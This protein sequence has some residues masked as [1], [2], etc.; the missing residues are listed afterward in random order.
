MFAT[1]FSQRCCWVCQP[2]HRL[3][4]AFAAL[5]ALVVMSPA[6]LAQTVGACCRNSTTFGC[7]IVTPQQCQAQ[8]GL[9]LGGTNCGVCDQPG[10]CCVNGNC[11][12][13]P[14]P[15][16]CLSQNGTYFPQGVACQ[17]NCGT[18]V[19]GACCNPATGQC[20]LLLAVDCRPPLLFYAGV[21]CQPSPCD[22]SGACCYVPA[23]AVNPICVQNSQS[24]CAQ[25]NGQWFGNTSCTAVNCQNV[26]ACCNQTSGTCVYTT[27]NQ[28]PTAG[29][30]FYP[31]LPCAAVTDCRPNVVCCLP[32]GACAVTTAQECDAVA[33]QIQPT[34]TSCLPNPCN[35][36]GACCRNGVCVV[37]PVGQCPAGALFLI[38]QGCVGVTCPPITGACCLPTGCIIVPQS[39]CPTSSVWVPST[40]CS[41]SPCPVLGACCIPGAACFISTQTDCIAATGMPGIW[42]ANTPCTATLCSPQG[43]CCTAAGGCVITTQ[44]QCSG[45]AFYPNATCNPNPCPIGGCCDPC[46]GRCTI[47]NQIDCIRRGGNYLGNG[48]PC[49]PRNCRPLIG[50][51]CNRLTGQCFLSTQAG[52]GSSVVRPWVWSWF[53]GGTC[54]PNP[55]R[56]I[57]W[58]GSGDVTVTDIFDYLGDWFAGV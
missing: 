32:T 33:G 20:Q 51:C 35:Q 29:N 34:A 27:Q 31:S 47:T 6:A 11:V 14:F 41:P 53:A 36:T 48:V 28:C 3:A 52:C 19:T 50:A 26:G 17:P 15:G 30:T 25:L 21:N 23:G 22:P 16:V 39:Q 58:N 1:R 54:S 13:V 56:R 10:S 8:G 4:S 44:A 45:L 57:D 24:A 40:G 2:A 42:Y 55:C 43:A 46:T 38:G 37:V 18:A 49:T 7:S 12:A 5:I 9:F